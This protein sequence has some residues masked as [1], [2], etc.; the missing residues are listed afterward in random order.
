MTRMD[1]DQVARWLQ[2]N[3]VAS[4]IVTKTIDALLRAKRQFLRLS[5]DRGRS[6][7]DKQSIWP[8]ATGHLLGN[9]SCATSPLSIWGSP[10][11]TRAE[12]KLVCFFAYL[13]TRPKFKAR[14]QIRN[15]SAG[16]ANS[17]LAKPNRH[18]VLCGSRVWLGT[19]RLFKL[20]KYL[21]LKYFFAKKSNTP[22]Q[23]NQLKSKLIVTNYNARA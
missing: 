17:P 20:L 10:P 22:I 3:N 6:N 11:Q 8:L 23:L 13:D 12:S 18:Y 2:R 5:R 4:D 15:L 14:Q 16:W 9:R 21:L 19:F 1:L 7:V